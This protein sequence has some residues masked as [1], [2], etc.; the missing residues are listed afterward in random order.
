MTDSNPDP[1]ETTRR[2]L[3]RPGPT[4]AVAAPALLTAL[5]PAPGR[6]DPGHGEDGDDHDPSGH[7]HDGD[8]HDHDDVDDIE[9]R[10]QAVAVLPR[11]TSRLCRV[12]DAGGFTPNTARSDQ[13]AVGL[14]RLL[15]RED[16]H[17][18][19]RIGVARRGAPANV[20]YNVAFL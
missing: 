15:G 5:S 4:L 17:D 9:E 6:A 19:D 3:L 1:A 10:L 14:V 8:D 16:N 7:G 12:N 20:S 11:Y 13:V 18:D 2:R